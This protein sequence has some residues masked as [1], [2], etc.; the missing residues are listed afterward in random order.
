MP[1]PPAPGPDEIRV[2]GILRQR[3]VGPDAQLS[4][5]PPRLPDGYQ[6][7][8]RDWLDDITDGRM[9]PEPPTPRTAPAP[10]PEPAAA[11]ATV[12][13]AATGTGKTG[14]QRNWSWLWAHVRPLHTLSAGAVVLAPVFGG[15][16]MVTGCAMVLN[17]MRDDASVGA[18]YATAALAL[19]IT[20][21]LD[22]N[23]Q[24]WLTRLLLLTAA[25]GSLGVLDWYDP[26]TF[27]TGVD[28]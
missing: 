25:I 9:D 28:Q 14:S 20:A 11:D 18:A 2:R 16:S 8:P 1:T 10:T 17:D 27:L 5:R 24:R 15:W 3:G 26:V 21:V 22:W 7:R 4:T 13:Q 19:T 6:E 12:E 23:R